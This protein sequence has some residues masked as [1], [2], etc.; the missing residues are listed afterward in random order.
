MASAKTPAR[1]P[2]A[3]SR[4]RIVAAATE[5]VRDHSYPELNVGQVMQ[6]AGIERTLYYRHFDDL[7][8]L[9]VAAGAESIE[10]LYSAQIDLGE[11]RDGSGTHPEAMRPAIERVVDF[12]ERHGPL[13]R[14]LSEA[15]AGEEKVATTQSAIRKR[16]DELTA[17]SLAELPQFES[18]PPTEIREI[19]R[20]LNLMNNAYLLDAFGRE[21]RVSAETAVRTLTTVWTGAVFGPRP[22]D[23]SG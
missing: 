14:A 8:D 1:L 12:Y 11:S 18:V 3:E 5:L 6:R 7:G 2:R 4:A 19:A 13:L 9:L 17:A 23:V 10:G 20:A 16:F 21:P 15:A 22:A